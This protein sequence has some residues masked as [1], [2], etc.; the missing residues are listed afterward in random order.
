MAR[1][2]VALVL[3]GL[4]LAACGSTNAAAPATSD[5]TV[6]PGP[7]TTQPP[8]ET[9]EAA[10]PPPPTTTTVPVGST[11]Q[12]ATFTVVATLPHDTDAFTQ[13]LI[14]WADRF[15]ES[16]GQ[17]GDSDL[18]VVDPT[19]GAV[20]EIRSLDEPALD[21]VRGDLEIPDQFF[22]EGLA[23]VDDRLVQLTWTAGLALVWDLTSLELEGV[24][25][26]SGQGWGLCHDGSRLVMS[27][28]TSDLT[29]RDPETFDAIGSV[30]V[31]W[32]GAPIG[33]L[34]ELECIDG[35]IWANIWKDNRILVID[36]TTGA[37]SH[38]LNVA[39]LIPAALDAGTEVLNGI[40]HDPETGRIWVTGKNWPTLYELAVELG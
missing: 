15:V 5:I 38:V 4:I 40:A 28:G 30:E 24:F 36:P 23:R 34:N 33:S 18:R 7:T 14:F 25:T 17:R 39:E 31:T 1:L 22:G 29:F 16:T 2:L 35:Q 37:V 32:A 19:T 3:A 11:P 6:L 8:V 26:Y 9:A 13:G 20:V 12:A 10:P 21:D 27:D